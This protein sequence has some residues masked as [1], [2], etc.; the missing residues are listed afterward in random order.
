MT[1]SPVNEKRQMFRR[2]AKLTELFQEFLGGELFF[3]LQSCVKQTM[4]GAIEAGVT[5][6]EVSEALATLAD[7]HE[8]PPEVNAA[9][10]PSWLTPLADALW[11]R[12][13]GE[14]VGVRVYYS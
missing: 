2:V 4:V 14:H 10:M 11:R 5:D 6:E 9:W 1:D 8:F 7:V 3:V 12:S 13:N